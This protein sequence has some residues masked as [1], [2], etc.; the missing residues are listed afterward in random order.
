MRRKEQHHPPVVVTIIPQKYVSAISKNLVAF[1]LEI[2]EPQR[3]KLT[4]F[5]DDSFSATMRLTFLFF[6][7][8]I[9]TDI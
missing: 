2:Y 6:V 8:L 3:M 7:K 9:L 5:G 1:C 4:D